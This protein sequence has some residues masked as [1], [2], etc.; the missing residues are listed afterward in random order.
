MTAYEEL[1]LVVHNSFDYLR[2]IAIAVQLLSN[3]NKF[4]NKMWV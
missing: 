3:L 2:T 1:L 4:F